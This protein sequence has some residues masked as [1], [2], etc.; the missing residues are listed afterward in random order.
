MDTE[1]QALLVESFLVKNPA[2]EEDEK[3]EVALSSDEESSDEEVEP[4]KPYIESKLVDRKKVSGSF[5]LDI[6]TA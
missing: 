3:A 2:V 1:K 5:S 4:K 6:G